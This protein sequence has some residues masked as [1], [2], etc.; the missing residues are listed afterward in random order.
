MNKVIVP[1]NVYFNLV[2]YKS[3]ML[4]ITDLLDYIT[5]EIESLKLK[6]VQFSKG[7]RRFIAELVVVLNNTLEHQREEYIKLV[8]QVAEQNEIEYTKDTLVSLSDDE[9]ALVFENN[10]NKEENANG[11]E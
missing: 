10:T 8:S 1:Q 2:F 5:K 4:V 11:V 9:L 6:G 3:Y 7:T